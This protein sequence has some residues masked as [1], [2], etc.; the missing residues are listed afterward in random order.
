[1]SDPVLQSG[2]QASKLAREPQK[3]VSSLRFIFL[4]SWLSGT[5]VTSVF[6]CQCRCLEENRIGGQ[7]P[8]PLRDRVITCLPL[9]HWAP[10]TAWLPEVVVCELPSPA[11]R[12]CPSWGGF[13][14]RE[15]VC[16][17]CV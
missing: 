15:C 3:T 7:K 2:M 12:A 16:S 9:L 1:M 4:E 13:L 8:I 14:P 5:S 6:Q 11:S 17:L 10:L